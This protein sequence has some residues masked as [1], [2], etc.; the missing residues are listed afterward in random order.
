MTQIL[1]FNNIISKLKK[2][3]SNKIISFS[4][5]LTISINNK[6]NLYLSIDYVIL[7]FI[8]ALLFLFSALEEADWSIL[9]A[10]DDINY[11]LKDDS[12]WNINSV[13]GFIFKK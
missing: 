13:I 6:N 12:P 11:S 5:S 7:N 1:D 8:R 10:R 4:N 3:G 2:K 9:S